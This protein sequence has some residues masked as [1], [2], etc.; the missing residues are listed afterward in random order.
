MRHRLA[1]GRH[2]KRR[3]IYREVPAHERECVICWTQRAGGEGNWV[4]PDAGR[5]AGGSDEG[6]RATSADD[7]FRVATAEGRVVDRVGPRRVGIAVETRLVIAGEGNGLL[8]DVAGD[9]GIRLGE[10]AVEEAPNLE[11]MRARPQ[12]ADEEGGVVVA[13]LRQGDVLGGIRLAEPRSAPG[14]SRRRAN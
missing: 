5:G 14:T 4:G 9:R 10:V 12:R 2:G 7:V 11:V 6:R 1:V 8:A 13:V 3:G